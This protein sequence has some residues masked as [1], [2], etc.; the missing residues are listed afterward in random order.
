M[1]I[2]TGPHSGFYWPDLRAREPSVRRQETG[3]V[4]AV[5][6]EGSQESPA[7]GQ[8][9]QDPPGQGKLR[10]HQKATADQSSEQ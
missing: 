6:E 7:A 4:H 8:D 3:A 5:H 9:S 10:N 2:R 1:N